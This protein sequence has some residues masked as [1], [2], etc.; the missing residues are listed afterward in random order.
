MGYVRL[1]VV[2]NVGRSGGLALFW[3]PNYN[4]HLLK[5]GRNFID[6]AI[7]N[8][9]GEK[10]RT[11]C[12]YCFPESSRRQESRNL[13]RSLA[14]SS[15]L[16]WVVLGDFNDLLNSNEK[17]G[18]LVHPNW[19]LQGFKNVVSNSGLHDLGMEG[20]QFMWERLRGNENWVEERLDRVL[21]SINEFISSRELSQQLRSLLFRPPPHLP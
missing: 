2:K 20:Y 6:V 18:K 19:K 9:K 5:F 7:E 15:S 3:N 21:A 13:L 14:L 8:T 17:R 11:A 16:S 1:S 12:F 10:W 4:V